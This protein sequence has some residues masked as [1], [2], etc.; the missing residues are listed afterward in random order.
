MRTPRP[1]DR[2]KLKAWTQ[3]NWPKEPARQKAEFDAGMAAI[4]AAQKSQQAN[5]E[6]EAKYRPTVVLKGKA[7]KV[8]PR[9]K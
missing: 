5:S 4:G 1:T 3:S 9:K 2:I 7:P 8:T 6:W